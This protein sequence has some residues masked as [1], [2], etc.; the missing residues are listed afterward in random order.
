MQAMS[1]V[2]GGLERITNLFQHPAYIPTNPN[3]NYAMFRGFSMNTVYFHAK[4]GSGYALFAE[5]LVELDKLNGQVAARCAGPFTHW[6]QY[7]PLRQG[8]MKKYIQR[9]VDTPGLSENTKE[10]MSKSLLA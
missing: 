1:S 3:C 7:D 5:K 2:E 4:D 8:L 9:V 6:K 10:I